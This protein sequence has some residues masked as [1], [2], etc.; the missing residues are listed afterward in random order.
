MPAAPTGPAEPPDFVSAQLTARAE[1]RSIEVTGERTETTSTFVNPDGTVTV[2]SYA[3]IRRV[4]RGETWENVDSTL[5]QA[6]GKV[7]PKVAKAGIVMSPR[8]S[9]VPGRSP[10]ADRRRCPPRS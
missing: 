10:L 1:K 5:V 4:R 2:D 3:G 6:D 8:S 7:V 9:T